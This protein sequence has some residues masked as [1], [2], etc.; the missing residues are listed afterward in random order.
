MVQVRWIALAL[1]V[2][3]LLA[4]IIGC[5][6]KA[7]KSNAAARPA[8]R[9]KLDQIMGDLELLRHL[10][11]YT[12]NGNARNKWIAGIHAAANEVMFDITWSLCDMKRNDGE[13]VATHPVTI[14][15]MRRGRQVTLCPTWRLDAGRQW[16][17][18]NPAAQALCDGQLADAVRTGQ[19]ANVEQFLT[20]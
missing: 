4:G 20:P 6:E 10:G 17:C 11:N 2:T 3:V 1:L 16:I 15:D 5:R 12:F 18:S 14:R 13:V 19:I 9:A 7:N 8:E